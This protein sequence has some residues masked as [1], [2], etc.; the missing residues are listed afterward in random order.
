MN[1][2]MSANTSFSTWTG[3][4]DKAPPDI[5]TPGLL[6]RFRATLSPHLGDTGAAPA[7]I[8]WCIS[9]PAVDAAGLGPD[10]HP[11]KGGFLPPIPLPRRMWAGGELEFIDPLREGDNVARLSRIADVQT[12]EG[13]SGKLCFVTVRHEFLTERGLAIRERQ[14]I[15]YRAAATAPA[16]ATTPDARKGGDA[17][18]QVTIDPVML[19]RYSALTFN[20]HRIHYDEPYARDVE[21]Y[22]GLVIHGP[23]QATLM[24]N[25]AT[26]RGGSLPRR[27]S[28][29]GLSPV[30]GPQTLHIRAW[31]SEAGLELAS[32]T[33]ANVTAMTAIATW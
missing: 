10:G 33:A 31:T 11:A 23:L 6:D 14:D 1:N 22:P 13:R 4:T 21:F 12:K 29:R 9:P 8:H 32:V 20:G 19:F 15:V 27:F 26:A 17:E 5:L 2:P 3:R 18:W 30:C 24:L 7:G 25:L 28:F 16:P